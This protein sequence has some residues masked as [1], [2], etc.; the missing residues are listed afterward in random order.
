MRYI[1]LL[2]YKYL[3][4]KIA[5]IDVYNSFSFYSRIYFK[6]NKK[7]RLIKIYNK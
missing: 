3:V 1:I 5:Y 7:D 6:N 2:L 4:L